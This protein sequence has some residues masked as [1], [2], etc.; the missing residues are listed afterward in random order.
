MH[1]FTLF[2][3]VA[4]AT[5]WMGC[6]VKFKP[7]ARTALPHTYPRSSPQD[8][9]QGVRGAAA[10]ALGQFSE[11]LQPEVCEQMWM[12]PWPPFEIISRLSSYSHVRGSHPL[13]ALIVTYIAL[14][15][16]IVEH[17]E[18]VLPALFIA[19]REGTHTV[20]VWIPWSVNG[21]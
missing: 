8:P 2:A 9:D 12:Q 16:Q 5:E 14:T 13:S 6:G 4:S 15:S 3:A 1:C 11:H 20:Q 7:L 17:Y 21:V 10:F 19:M 18:T